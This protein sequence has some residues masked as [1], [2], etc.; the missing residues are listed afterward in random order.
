MVQ[1]ASN[2]PDAEP[3]PERTAPAPLPE[4]AS[5]PVS[6]PPRRLGRTL[7]LIAVAAVLGVVG[8]TAVGYGIQADREP[9]ALPALNQP[10]LAYPAKPLPKGQEPTPLSAAEDRQTARNGDL[11]KLLLPRPAGAKAAGTGDKPRWMTTAE[12]ASEYEFPGRAF[13]GLVDDGIRRVAGTGWMTGDTKVVTIRLVQFRPE[14]GAHAA[15]WASDQRESV[16]G[17]AVSSGPL[18]GSADGRAYVEPVK[19]EAGYE[20]MY[21]ARGIVHRGDLL[22]EVFVI[23]TKKIGLNEITSLTERQL[24][25]L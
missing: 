6:A 2:P 20:D 8:G 11:V 22:L 1:T 10:A 17:D 13:D 23:D 19:R 21:W 24:G 25:R 15:D 4:P 16:A 5:L 9:T 3:I 18:K 12:F 14:D 7:A